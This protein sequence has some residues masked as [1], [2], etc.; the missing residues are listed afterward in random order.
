MTPKKRIG[1]LKVRVKWIGLLLTCLSVVGIL[2]CNW[3]TNSTAS[4]AGSSGTG[5]G[6]TITIQ[7][8]SNP[9]PIGGT[10]SIMALVRDRSGAPAPLGTN[11]C[12]TALING[13]ILPGTANLNATIC[14]TTKNNLGQSIQTYNGRLATGNDTIEVS[15]Q[16]VIARATIT[17]GGSSIPSGWTI[18]IQ[19][20]TNPLLSGNTTTVLAVVRDNTGAPPATGSAICFN[21]TKSGFLVGGVAISNVC[22]TTDAVGQAVQTYLGGT[23]GVDTIEVTSQGVL[24]R[25]PITVY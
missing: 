14:E 4:S 25:E 11:I 21:S 17:V 18:T 6:W 8:G 24:A 1:L 7:A 12:F 10:S 22:A 15:S 5:T 16:G 23:T 2:S 13:F 20:G 3:G 19:I 9:I